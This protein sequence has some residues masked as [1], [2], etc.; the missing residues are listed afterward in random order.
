M[1]R[2]GVAGGLAG[3]V[4]LLVWAGVAFAKTDEWDRYGVR[5]VGLSTDQIA[6]LEDTVARLRVLAP[7]EPTINAE[8]YRRL[9][10][11]EALFGFPFNGPDLVDWLLRRTTKISHGG[12]RLAANH[13][14][15]KRLVLSD[16]FFQKLSPLERF[17]LL[18]HEA[19]HSDSGGFPHV[20]CPA[21]YPFV[22]ATQPQMD[23]EA[24]AACDDRP[25]GAY[26]FQA[27]FLFELY[28]RGLFD[29][30]EAGLL[31]NSTVARVLKR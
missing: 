11:F 1:M 19:R 18:I 16:V 6:V 21:A 10:R 22:S 26:A 29:Q 28:A 14:G 2:V 23:L 24:E 30:Q 9:S 17:Y 3:I 5:F 12:G 25:D 7:S 31:Y 15:G 8:T 20:P 4:G 13:Q 27:A